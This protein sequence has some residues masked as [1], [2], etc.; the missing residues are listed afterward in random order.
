M[1]DA[2]GVVYCLGPGWLAGGNGRGEEQGRGEGRN[3]VARDEVK[4]DGTWKVGMGGGVTKKGGLL[5]CEEKRLVECLRI[6]TGD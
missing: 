2:G 6:L 1:S 5:D 4:R 3:Q